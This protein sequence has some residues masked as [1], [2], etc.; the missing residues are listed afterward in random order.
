MDSDAFM[1]DDHL[2]MKQET[3]GDLADVGFSMRTRTWVSD[4]SMV[5]IFIIINSTI[6]PFEKISNQYRDSRADHTP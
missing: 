3:C 5:F 4:L 2:S 6:N 1:I